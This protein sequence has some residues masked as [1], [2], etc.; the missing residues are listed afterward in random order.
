MSND[1]MPNDYVNSEDNQMPEKIVERL[2]NEYVKEA[3]KLNEEIH[4]KFDNASP[5]RKYVNDKDYSIPSPTESSSDK[6][7]ILV[8]YRT[9][10]KGTDSLLLVSV[11]DYYACMFYSK[12]NLLILPHYPNKRGI[13]G[14]HNERNVFAE[15]SKEATFIQA[16]YENETDPTKI[17][18]GSLLVKQSFK[19]SPELSEIDAMK[20]TLTLK[21]HV[22]E[23]CGL[24]AALIDKHSVR[25]IE[26]KNIIFRG[27]PGTGKSFLAKEIAAYIVSNGGVKKYS[28]LSPKQKRQ[29]EFVQFHPS[30]DYTDFVEGLRPKINTDGSMGFKLEDGVFKRFVEKAR[31][32]GSSSPFVFIIDEINRGEI[33]KI[34]GELFFALDPGYRGEAG[35]VSTQ[36]AN[37]HENPEEKFFIP[38]NIYIIGT[39]NDIDRS[40]DSFDFAM[41]R[42]FRFIEIKVN[43]RR[44]EML[45]GLDELKKKDA[46]NRMTSLNNA[47]TDVE[48]LNENYH[49]GASYFLKL[50]TLSPDDLWN[51]YLAPLL[52]DYVR[53]MY[54]E[55][56]ILEKF[57]KAYENTGVSSDNANKG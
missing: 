14:N 47:I 51:D 16:E 7:S 37:L 12:Y 32:D 49:I 26:S 25:V 1:N 39:M 21:S 43:E 29:I 6:I 46:I 27:A 13:T 8:K 34:F 54:N 38:D 19:L 5:L 23:A 52:Q 44:E 53:G 48:E 17:W 42:R 55:E 31:D 35:E 24:T 11:D 3:I 9:N 33:S 18:Q 30:Y 41:R 50:A 36:Y 4:K 10:T 2:A 57:K 22:L 45:G 20:C 28:E 15:L 56:G 40:V